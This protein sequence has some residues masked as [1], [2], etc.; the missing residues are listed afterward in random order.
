MTILV[1]VLVLLAVL[2][3]VAWW[4]LDFD[5]S[6][7]VIPIAAPGAGVALIYWYGTPLAW[8]AGIALFLV[9]G[10]IVYVLV[11]RAGNGKTEPPK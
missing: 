2:A 7:A 4:F 3:L 10:A 6:E 8:A 9:A 11:R 5:M 1:G